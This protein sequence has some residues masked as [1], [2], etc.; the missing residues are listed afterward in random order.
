MSH[1]SSVSSPSPLAVDETEDK[2]MKDLGEALNISELM[3][4]LLQPLPLGKTRNNLLNDSV[5][6]VENFWYIN[7]EKTLSSLAR[8]L[9]IIKDVLEQD[10]HILIVN[11]NPK[12]RPLI[13]ES[14]Y[15]CLNSNVWFYQDEWIPG[16][17]TKPELYPTLFDATKCQ[18]S[19]Q[20]FR[21]RGLPFVNPHCPN[22]PTMDKARPTLDVLDKHRLL[23]R[24]RGLQRNPAALAMLRDVIS[25]EDQSSRLPVPNSATGSLSKLALVICLDPTYNHEVLEE[26]YFKSLLTISLVNSHSDLSTVNYP[27]YASDTHVGFQ[28]FF[29]QWILRVANISVKK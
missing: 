23:A 21:A 25:A 10:G 7:P 14:A 11:S 2:K 22:P 6:E 26:A 17:L 28:H 5:V 15:C 20:L 27:V 16:L 1:F 12:M 4:V 8:S 9:Y 19:Q 3:K 24:S 29:L 18:P 13:R